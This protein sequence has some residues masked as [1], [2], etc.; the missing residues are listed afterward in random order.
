MGRP[1]KIT[2]NDQLRDLITLALQECKN[3]LAKNL[4]DILEWQQKVDTERHLAGMEKREKD[5]DTLPS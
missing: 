1:K 5:V 2:L 3:E 4:I